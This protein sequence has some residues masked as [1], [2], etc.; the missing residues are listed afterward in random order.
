MK[1]VSTVLIRDGFTG[2]TLKALAGEAGVDKVLIYRY[3]G[4]MD[5]VLAA[6][7]AS[8]V[9]WPSAQDVVPDADTALT[10]SDRL[11]RFLD[12]TITEL[13]SRPLT[14]ELLAMEIGSPNPLTAA[15]DEAREAWGTDVARRLGRA[16]AADAEHLNIAISLI[17]AGVQNLAVRGRGTPVYSGIHIGSDDGWDQIRASL[18]WISSRLMG[19]PGSAGPVDEGV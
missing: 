3:F 8:S 2:L 5:A 9:F 1:A 17:L 14:L 13:R 19:P 4:P 18:G 6:F 15:L 7:A 16:H 11:A 12:R 10:E